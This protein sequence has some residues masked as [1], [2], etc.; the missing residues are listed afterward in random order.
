MLARTADSRF[1][2]RLLR[3]LHAEPELAVDLYLNA[4]ELVADLDEWGPVIQAN[5]DG[6]YDEATVI[7]RLRVARDTIEARLGSEA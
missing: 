3:A 1:A 7:Q 2:A 4:S 6:E 5:V